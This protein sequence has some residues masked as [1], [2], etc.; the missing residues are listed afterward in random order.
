MELI[1]E[2]SNTCNA[3]EHDE[4]KNIYCQKEENIDMKLSSKVANHKIVQL[5]NKFIPKGLVP[6][7]KIMSLTRLQFKQENMWKS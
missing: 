5:K 1:D 4:D 2:F 6:L 3:Q 7:E